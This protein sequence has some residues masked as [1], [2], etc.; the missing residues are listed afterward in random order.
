MIPEDELLF[1][2]EHMKAGKD[3]SSV[4]I[5]GNEEYFLWYGRNSVASGENMILNKET[6]N[7]SVEQIRNNHGPYQLLNLNVLEEFLSIYPDRSSDIYNYIDKLGNN[8]K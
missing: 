1:L 4:Q 5:T 6:F 8:S 2:A 3:L 7:A